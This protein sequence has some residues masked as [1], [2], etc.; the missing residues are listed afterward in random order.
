MNEDSTSGT[1]FAT[2]AGVG[3]L[4]LLSFAVTLGSFLVG[5]VFGVL[6]F[7]RDNAI[8]MFVNVSFL[9]KLLIA[10]LLVSAVLWL[11]FWHQRRSRG[12]R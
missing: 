12:I 4:F 1:V 9:A 5:C 3:G 10:S 8:R 11:R 7:G 2:F 6:L